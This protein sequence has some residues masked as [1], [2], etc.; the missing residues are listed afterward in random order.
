VA[1]KPRTKGRTNASPPRTRSARPSLP[2]EPEAKRIG[3]LAVQAFTAQR[4]TLWRIFHLEGDADVGLDKHIE[5]VSAGEFSESFFAQI[6]G[7]ESKETLKSK[8]FLGISIEVS[9]INYWLRKSEPIMLAACD[10]SSGR[11]PT[12]CPVY[13]EWITPALI[14]EIKE[15]QRTKTLRV[16]RANKLDS[17][18]NVLPYLEDRRRINEA[19]AILFGALISE[20][21]SES[22]A[23]D[24]VQS[25]AD[26]VKAGLPFTIAGSAVGSRSSSDTRENKNSTL[27]KV[28]ALIV[29][30]N[31]GAAEN[32]LSR[33]QK[34]AR[35]A[36]GKD[37][38]T[39]QRGRIAQMRGLNEDARILFE[40][41]AAENS[42]EAKYVG[43]V[44]E[45]RFRALYTP[46]IV[47]EKL[48]ELASTIPP[49][50]HPKVLATKARILA[51][52]GDFAGAK[53]LLRK[54]KVVDA[55]VEH[56]LI[57]YMQ[58]D[59]DGVLRLS[60]SQSLKDASAAAQF[61]VQTLAC[62]ALANRDLHLE[63]T[64][65]EEERL[66]P[67]T[68]SPEWN[69]ADVR[70]VWD[71]VS[72]V[73][74]SASEQGWPP[75]AE[76][77]VDI[78]GILAG[79]LGDTKDAARILRAFTKV[80]PALTVVR[81]HAIR[82][83]I[84]SD[85]AADALALIRSSP[86]RSRF[87]R[88][89]ISALYESGAKAELVDLAATKLLPLTDV[90]HPLHLPSLTIAFVCAR[91]LAR[92]Q[93]AEAF[94]QAL[95][96]RPEW[97]SDLEVARFVATM[98]TEPLKREIAISRLESAYA[99]HPDAGSIQ[100]H[101][102]L[103][104]VPNDE[105]TAAKLLG[106]AAAVEKRRR[107]SVREI[108][109]CVEA[110]WR[111]D[112]PD[113]ALRLLETYSLQYASNRSLLAYKALT[114]DQL[115]R[116]AEGLALLDQANSD[117]SWAGPV[118]AY[119]DI[120][121]RSGLY[122][123]A[124]SAIENALSQA[125]TSAEKRKWIHQLYALN[126]AN[127]PS[128][129]Q[130]HELAWRYGQLVDRSDEKDEGV[131]LQMFLMATTNRAI[132]KTIP[133]ERIS[134]FHQRAGAYFERFPDSDVIKR[135]ELPK[136]KTVEALKSAIDRL[137]NVDPEGQ[138]NAA[139]LLAQ[140][141]RGDAVVP[142]SWR[143]RLI[144]RFVRDFAQLWEL[145]KSSRRDA[146]AVQLTM[147]DGKIRSL[148]REDFSDRIPAVD[149]TT[150]FVAFDLGILPAVIKRY[151]AIA[152]LKKTLMAL[153]NLSNAMLTT[154]VSAVELRK[155]LATNAD[156]IVQL[157][158]SSHGDD[159]DV[160]PLLRE[161]VELRKVL[162]D[163]KYFLWTDDAAFHMSLEIDHGSVS[164]VCSTDIVLWLDLDGMIGIS[165]AVD[166]IAKLARW[167]V[168]G[169]QVEGRYFD[170]ALAAGIGEAKYLK[171]MLTNLDNSEAYRL[172]VDL[173]WDW[174][175]EYVAIAD[176][177]ARVTAHLALMPTVRAEV[178][179][180]VWF[181]WFG[182]VRLRTDITWPPTKQLVSMLILTA[183][184]IGARAAEIRKLWQAFVAVVDQINGDR[185]T[186]AIERE[187]RAMVGRL[188][189][190]FTETNYKPVTA[191]GIYTILASGLTAGT[192][193]YSA[194][195]VAYT[196][197]RVKL[198]SKKVQ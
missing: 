56:V 85:Q 24:R 195:E 2:R 45:A 152:V 38:D 51:A 147:T 84:L 196:D 75:S 64:G 121:V 160:P 53:R 72:D 13:Y 112:R 146:L 98:N 65:D 70:R 76:L 122:S 109:I 150:L 135:V 27:V 14:G 114:L 39:F 193:D 48:L 94:E 41:A 60:K 59:W 86:D 169:L 132:A 91:E 58:S 28:E 186:E 142:M 10:L 173:V 17:N 155:F 82:L 106:V 128:S 90:G 96:S 189:V 5:V 34:R 182:K 144:L 149:L 3:E 80:R 191:D 32:L 153:Q 131:F 29:S 139:I 19:Q 57:P 11:P 179:A 111:T 185:M 184:K 161:E 15:G 118:S 79:A 120:A 78:Y 89:E 16:R 140:L 104:F 125:T 55:P 95:G 124:I 20:E 69:Y 1:S 134:E 123:K 4:P 178:L 141:E 97:E 177:V 62:R 170:S 23:R 157:G 163:S 8:D 138:R 99:A 117:G 183:A 180:A 113:L 18:L 136:E 52:A 194:F 26:M 9:T 156:R 81:A 176:H 22:A 172:I 115:G 61:S 188:A 110:Y 143:P 198:Q 127:D 93:Q 25:V 71:R 77:I 74:S 108:G 54:V 68:G 192:A 100:D 33:E 49:I 171:E 12:N 154:S 37:E 145:T 66:S 168:R 190:E 6:K 164:R 130:L 137:T 63:P 101:L 181:T 88:E 103:A 105:P 165:Q 187:A 151:G 126:A 30:G 107:L 40:Q 158:D 148:K 166:C 92:V 174:K 44:F 175:A 36:I 50:E 116:A 35:P 21:G 102:F 73:M 159:K 67:S 129:S 87:V 133:A 162:S 31:D 46:D 167:N 119:V 42:S 7:S 83:A 43:A 197:H 47:P